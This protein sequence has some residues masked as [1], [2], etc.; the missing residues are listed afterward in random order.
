MPT[1]LWKITMQFP[2]RML[3]FVVGALLLGCILFV[4]IVIFI[5][6]GDSWPWELPQLTL[7]ALIFSGCAI[8]ARLIVPPLIVAQGRKK[9]PAQQCGANI[10]E[11]GSSASTDVELDV[12]TTWKLMGLLMTR[13]IIAC[14]LLEGVIFFLLVAFLIEHSSI[15]LSAAAILWLLLAS[16]FPTQGWAISWIEYQCRLLQEEQSLGGR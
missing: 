3:Q 16:H 10:R 7:L 13:T 8:F 12:D 14:A 9:I 2:L 1:D 15:A 5:S 11:G 4:T 6:L